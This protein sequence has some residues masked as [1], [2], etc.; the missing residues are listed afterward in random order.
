MTVDTQAEELYD[1]TGRRE[2]GYIGRGKSEG[3]T[4]S[5]RGI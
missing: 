1:E 4:I 2:V 5:Y 3:E